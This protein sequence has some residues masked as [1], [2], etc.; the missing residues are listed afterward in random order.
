LVTEPALQ[1]LRRADGETIAYLRRDGK[2]PAVLWLGGF[3]SDMRG[4]K[5]DALD[6][7]AAARGQAYL[8]FDYYGH[9]DSSGEFRKGTISRWRDDALAVIDALASGSVVIAASS[10]GAW[11][12]L[13]AARAPRTDQCAASHCSGARFHGSADV[14]GDAGRDPPHDHGGGGMAAS[15][16]L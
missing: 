10:M 6:A 8:R 2:R 7:W 14:A 5:A 13:L 16:G 9:G 12:A 4:T 11:I 3:K 1:T 15:V